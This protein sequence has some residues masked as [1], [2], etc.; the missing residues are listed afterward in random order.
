MDYYEQRQASE[1]RWVNVVAF[2][3]C[4]PAIALVLCMWWWFWLGWPDDTGHGP[5]SPTPAE[6]MAPNQQADNP[7]AYWINESWIDEGPQHGPA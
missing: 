4:T 2:L 6:R 3:L 7:P 5:A 1:R